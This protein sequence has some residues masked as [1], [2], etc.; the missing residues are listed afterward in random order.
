MSNRMKDG[1]R[2]NDPWH[3]SGRVGQGGR[4]PDGEIKTGFDVGDGVRPDG[5]AKAGTRKRKIFREAKDGT[6]KGNHAREIVS[7]KDGQPAIANPGN[8]LSDAVLA[9]DVLRVPVGGGKMGSNIAHEGE[10]P[11]AINVAER[12]AC[13]Y[14]PP[15]GIICDPFVGTG[16]TLEAALIHGRRGIGCD[17]RQ[18]QVD[19]VSRRLAVVQPD[20]FA[21]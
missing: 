20:L 17:I 18:S 15:G 10:A 9:G 2:V 3:Q 7:E 1:Q 6:V 12:F 19:K 8:V 13:W 14:V 11:M 4:E 5:S 21:G 16:T